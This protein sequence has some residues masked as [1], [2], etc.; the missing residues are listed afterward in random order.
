M[1]TL[2]K[3]IFINFIVISDICAQDLS[4]IKICIDPGHGGHEGDDR[5]IEETGFWESEGN[6]TKALELEKILSDLGA[7]VLLT[8]YENEDNIADDPSLSE[9]VEIANN[10]GATFFHSIHSNGAAGNANYTVIIYRE[11]QN[12]PVWAEAVEMCSIMTQE[13]KN[14]H[15]TTNAMVWGDKSAL[16]FNLGVLNGTS[17]PASLSEGSFHDYIPESWRLQN[18]DYRK[19]ESWAIAR[20]FLEYFE[21]DGFTHGIIAG[22]VRDSERTVD[23]TYIT[24][25][26]AKISLNNIKVA[27]KPL[28]MVYNGDDNNN[29]FFLFDSLQPGEYKLIF[30]APGHDKDSTTVTV[31]SNKTVF[32]DMYLNPDSTYI[33]PPPTPGD[34]R[35]FCANDSSLTIEFSVAARADSYVV[36]ISEDG[37]SFADS[38]VSDTNIIHVNNLND[39]TP[40]YFKIKAMNETGSSK[41]TTR[42]YGGAP[43]SND[44]TVL[45]VNGFDRSSN[46]R[47]DYVRFYGTPITEQEYGFSYCKNEEVYEGRIS[48]QNYDL[49]IWLL[50]DESTYDD[51]FNPVEQDS[52]EAFLKNG[53]CLFVSGSEVGWDLEGKSNHPT[54]ADKDFYHNYLKAEYIDDA[55]NGTKDIY[56]SCQAIAGQM[57]E[58]L[59]DF[60]FDNGSQGTINV[61]YPDAINAVNGAK[62]ILEYK[63]A[64]SKN[65][66]GTAFEG[67]FP[68]GAEKGKI[69]YF[70]FPFETIYP[71][72]KRIEVMSKIFDF[73]EGKITDIELAE[74]HPD[75]FYLHQ[76]HPNPFNPETTINFVIPNAGKTEINVYNIL[77]QKVRTLIDSKL[78]S[79]EHKVQFNAEN[80]ASG[81]YVYE[82]R[83]DGYVMQKRMILLK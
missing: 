55:P 32:A 13:I 68:G 19:H 37:V 6:L 50:G 70:G 75:E 16:G 61:R 17:M 14:A 25:A 83:I 80:L 38:A 74:I 46:T 52:V 36:Y 18:L 21:E 30:D 48:P 26:D 66:A 59:S 15:R 7:D 24:P 65:I 73:F 42:L 9:R 10:F 8:R 81:V 34:I 35:V 31:D 28:D 4:G 49:V 5:Y 44:T 78:L 82:L 56:H 67:I 40:Y 57:F 72:V 63:N 2:Y 12:Q 71:E 54:Q 60:S 62:N 64:P 27:L 69:I 53:G 20:S 43:S 33:A 29:G 3:L 11:V 47:F 76:N 1:K 23:Y 58:G 51:S 77:G 45:V 22:I 41:T 39:I 79:G